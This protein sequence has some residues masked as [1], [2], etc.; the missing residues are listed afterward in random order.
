MPK[1]LRR[2]NNSGWLG[3]VT[4][5]LPTK[6]QIACLLDRKTLPLNREEIERTIP[7]RPPFLWLD[8]VVEITETQV[9]AR[10]FVDPEF[11]L[12]TGHFPDFPVLP[13]VIQCEMAFQAAAI[14]IARLSTPTQG[15]IPFVT[16]IDNTRFRRMVRP[17]DTVDIKVE[18]TQRISAAFYLTGHVSVGGKTA[19]RVE[20]ACIMSDANA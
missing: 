18:L 19:T 20:F 15:Q 11:D 7:H 5:L 4:S 10:T 1:R 16:R 12:F 8:E 3:T 6:H 14:L 13:G 17:G 9:H 2:V